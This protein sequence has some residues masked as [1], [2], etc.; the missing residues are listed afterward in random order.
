MATATDR[1]RWLALLLAAAL[2]VGCAMFYAPEALASEA[3][4]PTIDGTSISELPENSATLTAQI[5]PQGSETMYGLWLVWQ[6]PNTSSTGEAPVMPQ[7]QTGEIPAGYGDQTVSATIT[8]LRPGYAYW[9]AVAALNGT[10]ETDGKSPYYFGFGNGASSEWLG[11]AIP[12]IRFIPLWAIRGAGQGAAREVQ[13]AEEERRERERPNE[14]LRAA[15][16]AA[17]EAAKRAAETAA[18]NTQPDEAIAPSCI[19]PALK[20]HT[21]RGARRA[22][23]K[24]HCRLGRVSYPRHRSRRRVLIVSAQSRRPHQRLADGAAVALRLAWGLQ[25]AVSS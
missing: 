25:A 14:E 22:L 12:Y 11:P 1:T 23:E 9:Y 16:R 18:G 10:G 15:S 2:F 6:A 20:G 3:S 21:L 17:E 19:V 4:I 5:D 24:A 7:M 13:R 8:D